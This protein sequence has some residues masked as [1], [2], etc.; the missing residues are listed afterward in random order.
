MSCEQF[1]ALILIGIAHC[2]SS[3]LSLSLSQRVSYTNEENNEH[4]KYSR[5]ILR[6]IEAFNQELMMMIINFILC[7][8]SEITKLEN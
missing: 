6:Q 5:W 8:L 3:T 1:R 7:Q 2:D 4:S